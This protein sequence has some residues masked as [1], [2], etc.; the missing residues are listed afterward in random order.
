MLESLVLT[1]ASSISEK[2][3][4]SSKALELISPT[5]CS[6]SKSLAKCPVAAPETI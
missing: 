5:P 1:S 3:S 6:L 4:D 2:P